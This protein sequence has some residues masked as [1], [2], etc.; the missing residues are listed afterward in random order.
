VFTKWV[1]DRT[2]C[3]Q[4]EKKL[5]KPDW[6]FSGHCASCGKRIY[7]KKDTGRTVCR[8][9]EKDPTGPERQVQHG[10]GAHGQA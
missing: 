6:D 7:V 1:D 4:C 2:M 5:R 8:D 3:R 9:C 10:L